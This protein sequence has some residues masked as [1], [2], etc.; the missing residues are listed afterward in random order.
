MSQ[1]AYTGGFNLDDYQKDQ[2]SATLGLGHQW[3]EQWAFSGDVSWDSGTGEPASVLNPTKGG[4]GL[5][6]GVQFNPAPNYFIAGG[7]R[8]M[9]IGDATAQDGTYYVPLP[10]MSE[11]AQQGDY[12]DNTAIAYGLKMGYRF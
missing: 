11:L 7:V 3:S 12:Q 8:Y 1:G 5:G 10:G 6:L 4:W 9:W 2:W